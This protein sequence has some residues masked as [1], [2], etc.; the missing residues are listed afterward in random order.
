MAA[1]VTDA[2]IRLRLTD[3]GRML[4]AGMLFFFVTAAVIPAFGVVTALLA[5][6]LLAW[7]VGSVLRPRVAITAD[8]PDSVVAGQKVTLRYGLQNMARVPAY[9]LRVRL[10]GMPE[11][12]EQTAPADAVSRLGLGQR[13]EVSLAVCPERRGHFEIPLPVCESSFPFN[14]MTFGAVRRQKRMLTV[15]PVHYRLSFSLQRLGRHVQAGHAGFAGR[16]EISP[17]YAGNR[18]FLPGDSPRRIDTRAWARLSV[19]ATKEYHNDSESRAVLVLDTRIKGGQRASDGE[20]IPELEAAVS[21][22]A[23]VAYTINRDCLVDAMLIGDEL[24]QY[25]ARRRSVRLDRIHNTLAGVQAAEEYVLDEVVPTL[26]DRFYE[27]T[28]AVF[29]LLDWDATYA[30]LVELAARARCHT[31]VFLVAPSGWHPDWTNDVNWADV[32]KVVSPDDVL[33]GHAERL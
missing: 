3:A 25:H 24:H 13:V 9:D 6:L 5:V 19:P 11:T 32:V 14:L 15:L 23:S 1:T 12:I 22:C 29:I 27:T 7:I 10:D 16:A 4:L 26:G 30:R 2:K 8:L 33:K 21:L 20:E 28:E 31:T 18:P 17:E